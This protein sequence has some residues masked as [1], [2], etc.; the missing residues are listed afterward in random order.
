MRAFISPLNDDFITLK[1]AALLIARERSGIEPGDIMETFTHAIF[2]D[3]FE[4][5]EIA[6][7]GVEPADDWNLPLLLIEVPLRPGFVR[8]LPLE[9]QPQEYFAVKAATVAEVLSVRDALPGSAEVWSAFA[10]SPRSPGVLDDTLC[11]LAHTPY[12]AFP[13]KAHDILSNIVISKIKLR[14]WMTFKG[15]EL[16]SFLKDTAPPMRKG[17]AAIPAGHG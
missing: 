8:R 5:E 14:A 12:A 1:R 2:A 4:R 3:E 13:S 10:E 17:G 7:R 9:S 16:P 6:V 11:A 15:Y